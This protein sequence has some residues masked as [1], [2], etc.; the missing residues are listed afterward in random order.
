MGWKLGDKFG[1]NYAEL[2]EED[3]LP[4]DDVQL[5]SE[6]LGR[7][8]EDARKRKTDR[9]GL[10]SNAVRL[11]TCPLQSLTSWLSAALLLF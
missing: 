1:S 6:G 8:Y 5:P 4:S 11:Q 2:E 10:G 3:V 9:A 7:F